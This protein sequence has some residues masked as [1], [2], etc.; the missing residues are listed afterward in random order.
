MAESTCR[1][2]A[3]AGDGVTSWHYKCGHRR[4]TVVTGVLPDRITRADTVIT[5]SR[6]CLADGRAE[7]A[8][9]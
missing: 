5:P 4:G 1:T 2:S 3:G 6:P 8:G 9:C 7:L